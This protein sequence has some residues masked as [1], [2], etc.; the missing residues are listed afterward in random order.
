M[1][2]LLVV[3]PTPQLVVPMEWA[4]GRIMMSKIHYESHKWS[5]KDPTEITSHSSVYYNIEF[6]YMSADLNYIAIPGRYTY[7]SHDKKLHNR[8]VS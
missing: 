2:T 8:Y 5:I 6:E 4:Q 3:L 7:N 1:V